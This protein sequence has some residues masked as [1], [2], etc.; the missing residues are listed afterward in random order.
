MILQEIIELI[1]GV[2]LYFFVASAFYFKWRKMSLWVVVKAL[3]MKI[4]NLVFGYAG[5]LSL[6][7]VGAA[8][9]F[10]KLFL[11]FGIGIAI[12][13]ISISFVSI[14]L[15]PI[16][17]GSLISR[18]MLFKDKG[19]V[20]HANT[21]LAVLFIGVVSYVPYLGAFLLFS[22]F[23]YVLALVSKYISHSIF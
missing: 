4:K 8:F 21:L 19:I 18:Y 12:V 3:D 22:L 2:T 6:L 23:A 9:C 1:L 14:L 17:L 7:I 13:L 5:F 20:T 10:N 16:V 15:C 11:I